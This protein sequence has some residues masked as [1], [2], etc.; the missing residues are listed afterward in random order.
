M[1]LLAR[2]LPVITVGYA[3]VLLIATHLPPSNAVVVAAAKAPDKFWHFVAY[4]VLGFLTY[5]S[6]TVLRPRA[7]YRFMLLGAGLILFAVCD[8]LTQ[9]FFGRTAELWD[10]VYDVGGIVTGFVAAD[11]VQRIVYRRVFGA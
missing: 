1:Y 2:I 5:A 4:A 6:D 7:A 10:V 8:E 3:C 11:I 9:P